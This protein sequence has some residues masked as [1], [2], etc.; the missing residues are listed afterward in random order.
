MPFPYNG[1]SLTQ[2]QLAKL[3]KGFKVAP[4]QIRFDDFHT[5][6]G[7]MRDWF[8]KAFRY[9]PATAEPEEEGN[10]TPPLGKIPETAKQP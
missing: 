5:Y 4:K 7:Y 10:G 2:L 3:L 8:D 9:I 6:K 1:K